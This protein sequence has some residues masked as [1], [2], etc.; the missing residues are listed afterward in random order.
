M[1]RGA[2]VLI[3]VLSLLAVAEFC[4]GEAEGGETMKEKRQIVLPYVNFFTDLTNNIGK[5]VGDIITDAK[6]FPPPPGK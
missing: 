5:L 3:F 4:C 6:S 1:S 2:F